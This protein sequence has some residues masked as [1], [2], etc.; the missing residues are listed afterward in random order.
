MDS[1]VSL[2]LFVEVLNQYVYYFDQHNEAV[3]VKFMNNLLELIQS[4]ISNN[5]D[6]QANSG[7]R[8][9]F[10]KT[11]EYIRQRKETEERYAGVDVSSA[12][13]A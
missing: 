7:P 12:V 1:A 10:E 4:N 11:L 9:N 8:Q 13:A 2:E 3:T 5:E 6:S